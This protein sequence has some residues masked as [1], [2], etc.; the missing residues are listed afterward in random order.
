MKPALRPDGWRPKVGVVIHPAYGRLTAAEFD[1][2]EVISLLGGTVDAA[3]Y[4]D[5]MGIKRESASVRLK[6][7]N[8]NDLLRRTEHRETRD[9]LNI[10]I[11]HYSISITGRRLLA[12]AFA[13]M[14]AAC[15]EA[16]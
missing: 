16:A 6:R 7:L 12:E 13:A 3:I 11:V 14:D 10:R 8:V 5:R 15:E 1:A 4:A 9:G 2:L